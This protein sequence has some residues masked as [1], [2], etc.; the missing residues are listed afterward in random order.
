MR[1]ETVDRVKRGLGRGRTW[2]IVA[3]GKAAVRATFLP[4]LQG[5]QRAR[6]KETPTPHIAATL[7]PLLVSLITCW[8]LV[9]RPAQS[10]ASRLTQD[11]AG[12]LTLCKQSVTLRE[13]GQCAPDLPWRSPAGPFILASILP[14]TARK[15]A[16]HGT[17]RG[18]YKTALEPSKPSFL[19]HT[20][21]RPRRH[22][23]P[24]SFA[25]LL[26]CAR[27]FLPHSPSIYHLS[28]P[29]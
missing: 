21:L 8:Q 17:Q 6:R 10:E 4:I 12:P 16:S 19:Y 14:P 29:S 20:S 7:Q 15:P 27:H 5:R 2:G 24:Q 28:R 13:V 25:S 18:A 22:C 1:T 23:C 3:S 26:P 11:L 9:H